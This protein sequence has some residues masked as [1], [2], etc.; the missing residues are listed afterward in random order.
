MGVSDTREESRASALDLGLLKISMYV[1][2]PRSGLYSVT[3]FAGVLAETWDFTI[4]A[5][6]TQTLRD[7]SHL[8][9]YKACQSTAW[10][11]HHS[12]I[13][14]ETFLWITAP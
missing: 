7:K 14:E 11:K 9:T 12:I 3:R 5:P 10:S 6:Y 8:V 1:F 13:L 4:L 2:F